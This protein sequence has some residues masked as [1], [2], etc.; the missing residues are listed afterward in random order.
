MQ[1]LVI[2]FSGKKIVI[3][4]GGRIAARKARV[5]EAEQAYITFVAP[6]FSEEVLTLSEE[7]GYRLIKRKAAAADFKESMLAILATNDRQA[8]EELAQT[9]PPHQ[10]VC[11]VDEFKE[12]NVTFPATVRRGHL[13]VAVTSNGSSPKL[14]RKLKK[15]LDAQFDES[16]VPYTAFLKECRE[17]IKTISLSEEAKHTL[18][19]E[20]LDDSLRLDGQAREAKWN[21][22]LKLK[23]EQSFLE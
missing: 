12:G 16:W 14:T 7:K 9:L 5:L 10:L 22:L 13:Q 23:E 20:L 3:A 19:W 2:N 4:G 21:E 6:E 15:E 11:V 8:N 18:L 17:L 1:P